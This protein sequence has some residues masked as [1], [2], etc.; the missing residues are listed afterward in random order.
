MSTPITEPA[1]TPATGL[2]PASEQKPPMTP[3]NNDAAAQP[4]KETA[5]QDEE[6]STDWKA[7]ARLWE[8]RAKENSAAAKKLADIEDAAKTTEQRQADKIAAL[9]AQIKEF[10]S[11]TQLAGWHAEVAKATGLPVNVVSVLRGDTLEDIQAAGEVIKKLVAE[12]TKPKPVPG[13]GRLPAVDTTATTPGLGTLRA[14][15]TANS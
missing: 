7:K 13:E 5:S 9:E 2:P 6:E 11:E 4:K 14:A 3:S 12:S 8:S 1:S 10:E 15:F